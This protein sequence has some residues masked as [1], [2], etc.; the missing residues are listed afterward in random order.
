MLGLAIGLRSLRAAQVGMDLVGQNVANASTP[1]YSRRLTVLSASSPTL[2][3]GRS[4]GTGVEVRELRRIHD[5]LLDVRLREQREVLGHLETQGALLGQLEGFFQEPSESG[6]AARLDDLW[7][8]LSDVARS[9]DDSSSRDGLVQSALTLT[10]GFRQVAAQV[11]SV[12][13]E[14]RRGVDSAVEVVNGITAEIAALNDR[15]IKARTFGTTPSDLLDARDEL[16]KA[17]ADWA[18]PQVLD[19][20]DGTIDVLLDGLLLVSGNRANGLATRH[21]GDGTVEVRIFPGQQDI[22][23]RG[24]RLAGYLALAH[25]A[26][27]QRQADLDEVARALIYEVNKRHTTAV[28]ASGPHTQLTAAVTV[29]AGALTSPLSALDLPFPIG[30]GRLLVN[31][32]EAAS[33]SVAQH[34]VDIDPD[35]MTLGDLAATL[36]ALPNLSASLDSVG[37][38]RVSAAAGY[39]FDFSRR[40]D[41]DPDDAGAFGSDHATLTSAAGPFALAA[42]DTLD[43]AVDGGAPI[44]ITFLAGDFA[45][46]TAATAA[47]VAAVIEAQAPG[48]STDVVDGRLVLR[49]ASVG[50]ASSLTVTA[51]SS[52]ALFAAGTADFGGDQAVAVRLEGTPTAGAAGHY[53]VRALG[54]GVIGLTPGLEVGLFDATGTQIATFDAGSG[55]VPGDPIELLPGVALTLTPGSVSAAA[56]D[57]FEFDLVAEPDEADVLVALQIGAFFTGRGAAD[58]E[59]DGELAFDPRKVAGS[60]TGEAG[61]ASA[62][63]SMIT[64]RDLPLDV[65]SGRTIAQGYGELVAGVGLDVRTN[66]TAATAQRQLLQSLESRREE[67]AG[68]NTDEEMLKLLEYQ[69]LYQAAGRYLQSV[70]EMTETLFSIL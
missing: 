17:L 46:I 63:L 28:P 36:D 65:L 19:R 9:A 7:N 54:E 38:L 26:V 43:L 8:A 24:G 10:A 25:G 5:S 37:R 30:T 48:I 18:D 42:G 53:T 33:G 58:L 55:Y 1:G 70:S 40:L 66:A 59:L 3:H 64:L 57:V 22:T 12:G 62:F 34:F 21:P 44:T 29:D 56:G 51:A 20:P 39:G 11:G 67:I 6:L 27:P 60:A 15:I 69:H 2:A 13:E 61:D 32:V 16:V 47:E 49:S 41:V 4:L 35:A 31:V 52:P 23:V 45:D 14:A 50:A 68:V